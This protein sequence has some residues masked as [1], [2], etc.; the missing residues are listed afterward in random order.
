MRIDLHPSLTLAPD[1]PSDLARW[2]ALVTEAE[3]SLCSCL[4]LEEAAY[5]VELLRR[6][7][8]HLW[9][10]LGSDGPPSPELS[11]LG[12]LMLLWAGL[13]PEEVLKAGMPLA[14]VI[15]RG[16]RAYASLAKG[17]EGR[18]YADLSRDFVHLVDLLYTM[19]EIDT[20]RVALTPLQAWDLLEATGSRYAARLIARTAP[21]A[22]AVL[23][24]V[25]GCH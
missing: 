3:A 1:S 25:A 17:E 24:P 20:G 12:D 19:R 15:E 8:K 4:T 16:R 21:E 7:Q 2:H 18:L 22:T 10:A 9:R 11:D 5:L 14:Q 6:R 23:L 13:L